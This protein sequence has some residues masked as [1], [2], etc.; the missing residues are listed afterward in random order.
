[1]DR[2]NEENQLTWLP[3]ATQDLSR[4]RNFIHTHNPSAAS[5]AA[6]RILQGVYMIRSNPAIGVEVEGLQ[7][8]RDLTL[9]FGN[10]DYII[11]YRAAGHLIVIVRVRHSREQGF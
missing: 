1:M 10:G 11:R 8:Y 6:K 5:R 4:L 3:A 9:P 7:G 2:P